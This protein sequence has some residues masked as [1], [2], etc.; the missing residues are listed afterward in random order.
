MALN[1]ISLEKMPDITFN[2]GVQKRR[3]ALLLH[4]G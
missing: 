3:S 4:A 1:S 2:L